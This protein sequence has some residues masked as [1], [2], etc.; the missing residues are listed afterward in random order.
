M[1]TRKP[2]LKLEGESEQ[3]NLDSPKPALAS[4]EDWFA[5]MAEKI[6]LIRQ[7]ID[8]LKRNDLAGL[9]EIITQLQN[10]ALDFQSHLQVEPQFLMDLKDQAEKVLL[11]E[12]DWDQGYISIQSGLTLLDDCLLKGD[13]K[14]LLE[15]TNGKLLTKTLKAG[16][17]ELHASFTGKAGVPAELSATEPGSDP[18]IPPAEPVPLILPENSDLNLIADFIA[19]A[20]EHI[21]LSE[22]S[23]LEVE[24][25][26]EN[27]N[28][29]HSVFRA[30][31]TIKGTAGFLGL[32]CITKLAHAME[33]LMDKARNNLCKLGAEHVDLL[34][35]SID[36]T[37]E[38]L[39]T[40]E[41]KNRGETYTIP[42]NYSLL[43][44]RL[45]LICS[46]PNQSAAKSGGG[47]LGELLVQS[48]GV[49][50][51]DLQ[52]AL[53]LQ[54]KGDTR[55]LG[56]I[57]IATSAV[58]S[59]EIATA[60]AGQKDVRKN[61]L[62]E[63]GIRVPINKLDQL[64]DNIGEAVIANSMVAADPTLAQASS[65]ELN[66][67]ISSSGI[68][69][70]QVQELSMS[71]RMVSIKPCF[72]KMARLVRDLSKKIGK[73]VEFLTEGENTELDKSVVERIDD[74]LMH[75][76]RNALDH[77]IEPE[78]EDR[79][80]AGK[81]AQA[82]VCLRAYHKSGS[83]VIELEDDGRGLNKEN[84]YKKALEKGLIDE[85]KSYTEE[86]IFQFIFLPGFSTAEKVTEVSGRGVGM[87]VVKKNIHA[88]RG[89][90]E[91]R[92]ELGK[93]SCFT[94][95][96]PLT[97]AIIQ[98]MVV[99]L[100]RDR[101]IIP[102]LS[103]ITTLLPESRQISTVVGRGEILN[104]RGE[105][106]PLIRLQQI[107]DLDS[108]RQD[109]LKG[110]GARGDIQSPFPENSVV[111]VVEDS[112]GKRCGVMV[113][114]ILDQQQVVIKN[115]GTCLSNNPNLSGGAIMSDGSIS[116][117]IDISGIIKTAGQLDVFKNQLK[118]V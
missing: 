98:G 30:F 84:I 102:T 90:V 19:E 114:E 104:L 91:I 62:V 45:A 118:E 27:L 11:E 115:L 117:I 92:S 58:S 67:K 15:K 103:I 36:C 4:L 35:E 113:D 38:I 23:L 29:I 40:L 61:P 13:Y 50:E 75:M 20:R 85:R 97:L 109:T 94:I 7:G 107:F 12:I 14:N 1:A 72:Q 24:G 5:V 2:A 53:E 63:E 95:R 3:K 47:K 55:K 79:R 46:G 44:S 93:G 100:G 33:S 18:A 76:V 37:K 71:L 60:L 51:S 32:T 86:E 99:R 34:L 43:L 26:P 77:G 111:L 59:R 56:E 39:K 8:V 81:S 6:Q 116:L 21:Y 96:L 74:P 68:I 110:L 57:L 70:R 64:I 16:S 48:G 87:D 65:T 17:T 42:A 73:D 28:P 88:L 101:Y 31:H 112:Q 9:V 106:I 108:T 89:A 10:L 105:L 49:A 22:T 69:M 82:R 25:D 54:E 78:V 80:R 83:V 41:T 66:R 52:K